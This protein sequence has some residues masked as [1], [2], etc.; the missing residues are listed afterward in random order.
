MRVRFILRSLGRHGDTV[1]PVNYNSFLSDITCKAFESASEDFMDLPFA[2]ACRTSEEWSSLFTYSML[3]GEG[4]KFLGE[5]IF[6]KGDCIYWLLSSPLKS[7]LDN[8]LV[9]ALAPGREIS[10]GDKG[11]A[12][13]FKIDR[14]KVLPS[15]EFSGTMHF[16]CMSPITV[17]RSPEKLPPTPEKVDM[18]NADSFINS[19]IYYRPWES[20]FAQALKKNLER[21]YRLLTGME[22]DDEE[23][24]IIV[25]P[26][27]LERRKGKVLKSIKFRDERVIGFMA[28]I[29]VTCNPE[30]MSIGYEAGF[31]EKGHMGFGMVKEV[32][33]PDD[34][35]FSRHAYA[36]EEAP[37]QAAGCATV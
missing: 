29:T 37:Q 27:Y 17:R 9:G 8:L 12:A 36:Q 35:F 23:F 16:T 31:G 2:R 10:I 4:V 26:Q 11:R 24:G 28:P 33:Q 7:L 3:L 18:K 22:C 21:K 6:F 30:L 5:R 25:D 19:S 34:H 1:V 20:G 15:P 13:R 14:V 32:V